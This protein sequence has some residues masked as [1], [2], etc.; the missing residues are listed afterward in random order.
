MEVHSKEKLVKIL[1]M[2]GVKVYVLLNTN[3]T[4]RNL[5]IKKSGLIDQL[6]WEI[7]NIPSERLLSDFS[8]FYNAETDEVKIREV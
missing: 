3:S 7:K 8:A 6:E 5:E 1:K 4:N 2:K